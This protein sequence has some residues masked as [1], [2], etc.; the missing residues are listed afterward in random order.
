MSPPPRSAE[1]YIT[2]EQMLYL[3]L[4]A[5]VRNDEAEQDDGGEADH[6]L[7]GQGVD[8]ALWVGSEGGMGG[9]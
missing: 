1:G 3:H 4:A 5:V 6:C 7:E 2:A 8:G 9:G